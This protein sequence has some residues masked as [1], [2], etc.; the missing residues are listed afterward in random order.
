MRWTLR[1]GLLLIVAWVI[2]AIS[3]YVALYRL[4][5]AVEERNVAE[6][7]ERINF[8]T[9]RGS[10]TKQIV[11]DYLLQADG[12]EMTGIN[13][14][15]AAEATATVADPIIAQILTPDVVVDLLD[16]G[17]PQQLLRENALSSHFDLSPNS[18]RKAWNFFVSSELRGF[19]IIY[20][21]LPADA[22]P[23]N[24][25]RLQMR[26]SG[27][28]WRLSGIDLPQALRQRL[29]DKLPHPNGTGKANVTQAK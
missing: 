6:I 19:R 17:W 7:A 20:F 9:L 3:P 2:F 16:D 14:Q 15:I 28:R 27:L 11:G 1:I 24:R 12:K 10:L 23:A 13:R 4:S 22:E 21:S 18:L 5:K 25:Y 29:L 8:R 26:L